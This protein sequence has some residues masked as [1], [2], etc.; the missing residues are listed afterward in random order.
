VTSTSDSPIVK[1]AM[2]DTSH[3]EE[4]LRRDTETLR[5]QLRLMA[6]LVLGSL[7]GAVKALK[8][9]DRKLAYTVILGDN[10]IDVLE[11]HID[12]LCQEYLVRH[13]PVAGQLRFVVAVAK[14]NSELERMGDYAEGIA[15]RAVALSAR[16]GDFPAAAEIAE[17]SENALTMLRQ[18]VDAFLKGDPALARATLEL[19]AKVNDLNRAVYDELSHPQASEDDLTTRFH[20]LGAASRLERVADRACNLAEHAIYVSEGQVLRHMPRQDLRVLFLCEDNGARSQ[21]AEAIARRHA[22]MHFVFASAGTTPGALDSRAQRFMGQ[23][24]LD[25]SRHRPK[26]LADVGNIGDYNVVV[27]LCQEAEES[28]PAVPYKAVAL[29]W[30]I[31]DPSK[32]EGPDSDAAYAAVYDEL[33]A[34]IIELIE[35][36]SGARSETK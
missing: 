7:D 29:E 11:G 17:M 3:L 4:H 13:M 6:D 18:S 19:D 1:K 5:R 24:G 28:R 23:K 35:S 10:R 9:R 30:D 14:V 22:P 21:M 25:V 12:R 8:T 31:A 15:R 26:A 33:E 2:V 16:E 32:V 27:S 34:K 20:L 36:M